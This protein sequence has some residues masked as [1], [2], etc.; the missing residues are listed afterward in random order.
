MPS[1][2]LWCSS[3]WKGSFQVTLDIGSQLYYSVAYE[4][5]MGWW[6]ECMM[7]E[8]NQHKCFF[9][10]RTFFLLFF[11]E[12]GKMNNKNSLW[13]W[14]DILACSVQLT[15]SDISKLWFYI[16]SKYFPPLSLSKSVCGVMVIRNGFSNTSSNL[17]QGCLLLFISQLWVNSRAN[18]YL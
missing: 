5:N 15:W 12:A 3:Y 7:M 13:Q 1:P 8:S 2:T 6:S 14:D 16:F 10:H 17:W 11:L 18:W 4:K 9:K